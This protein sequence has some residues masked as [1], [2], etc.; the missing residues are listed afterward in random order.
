M[1]S[2]VICLLLTAVHGLRAL[3]MHVRIVD[4][5]QTIGTLMKHIT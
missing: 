4:V 5:I 3:I 1:L 2:V